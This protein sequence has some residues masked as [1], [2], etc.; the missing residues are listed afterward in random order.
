MLAG[1]GVFL[2][3]FISYVGNNRD[4]KYICRLRKKKGMV[5]SYDIQEL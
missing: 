4:I 5:D 1:R 3:I 2:P